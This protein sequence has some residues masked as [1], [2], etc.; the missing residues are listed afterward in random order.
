LTVKIPGGPSAWDRIAGHFIECITRGVPATTLSQAELDFS[1]LAA[2]RQS[3]ADLRPT[4][5]LNCAAFTQVDDCETKPDYALR[6]N[7]EAPG[8]M[9]EFA[10]QSGAMLVHVSSDYVFDGHGPNPYRETDPTGPAS[11]TARAV[12]GG[13]WSY[14]SSLCRACNRSRGEPGYRYNSLGFRVVLLSPQ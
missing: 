4:L 2:L 12:R 5:I 14:V 11:G 8:V 1:D 3:L 9:A 7:G 13:S 10:R 6:I